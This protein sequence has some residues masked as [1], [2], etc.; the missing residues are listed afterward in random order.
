M[1]KEGEIVKVVE[2][3]DME[4]ELS[5]GSLEE[6]YFRTVHGDEEP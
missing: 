3:K 6:L 1:L 2:S 4:K 5:G